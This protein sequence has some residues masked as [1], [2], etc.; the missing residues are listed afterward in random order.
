M[1]ID[2]LLRKAGALRK[3]NGEIFR[4]SQLVS[5]C[6]Y[7]ERGESISNLFDENPDES[8]QSDADTS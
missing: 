7:M 3:K 2:T 6:F 5:A 1:I 4:R 8:Q